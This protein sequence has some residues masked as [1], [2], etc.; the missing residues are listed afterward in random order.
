MFQF[1]FPVVLV[2]AF[3]TLYHICTKHIP[4]SANPLAL[5]VVVYMIAAVTSLTL[6]LC[7]GSEHDFIGEM[8]AVT[9]APV[10]LGFCVIGLEFG[11]ILIY[12]V[13]WNISLA[14]LVCNIGLA[15]I[16][17][18][19]GLTVYKEHL[20]TNQIIGVCLCLAGLVFINKN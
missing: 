8:K 18:G 12:R 4:Q 11:T 7:T 2:I 3:N 1:Y 16:L 19:I 20:H 5:L 10:I 14:S 17:I 15:I 9:W 13:G 6:F